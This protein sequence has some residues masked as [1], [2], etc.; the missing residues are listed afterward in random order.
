MVSIRCKMFVENELSKLGLH[1]SSLELGEVDVMGDITPDQFHQLNEAFTEVGLEL[2]INKKHILIEKIK[3]VIV[4]MFHH[5]QD[6]SL[7]NFSDCLQQKLNYDYNYMAS[8]FSESVGIS[9]EHY[10]IAHKIENIKTLLS[11]DDMNLSEISY[12]LNYKNLPHLSNQFKQ[13]TG[14]TPSFYKALNNM[15]HP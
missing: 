6:P 8:I 11:H 12:R 5:L 1:C 9:I 4:E 15:K 13:I 14:Q 3:G 2:L 7:L 10:I